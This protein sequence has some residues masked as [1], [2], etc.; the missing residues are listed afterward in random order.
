MAFGLARAISVAMANR[1]SS[2]V[3]ATK[4]IRSTKFICW[5]ERPAM[6]NGSRRDMARQLVLGFTQMATAF[7]SLP[8]S[9]I[10][11]RS[12]NRK[13]SL[14]SEPRASKNAM[15][16][17][18]TKTSISWNGIARRMS[19]KKSR[20]SKATMQ[21]LRIRPTARPSRF[22]RIDSPINPN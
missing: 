5:I 7:C 9:S 22:R 19:T 4:K 10:R 2:K 16:G 21:R 6:W 14:K 1:W 3:N 20:I 13:Q 15:H 11:N 12:R 8:R 17:I 18:T